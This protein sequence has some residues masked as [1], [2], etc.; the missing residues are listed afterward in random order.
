MRKLV[1]TAA[2]VSITALQAQA[3][4]PV[5][6]AAEVQ[7]AYKRVKEN[8]LKAVEKMPDE[9]FH[10]KPHD[11]VRTYA[12]VVNHISEAQQATCSAVLG[13][14]AGKVPPET[15]SK[16]D[17]MKGL[18]DSFKVCDDAYASVTDANLAQQIKTARGSRSR[19]GA[20]WG[21]VSHDNEQ[22]AILS[23]YLRDKNILPPTSE[24]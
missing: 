17:I 12:R 10:F 18:Q 15:A 2:V 13:V 9:S 7:A 1:L 24:K 3:P 19:I 23:D 4:A 6:P 22:Y 14:E 5:G 21:N 8:V 20:L 11:D 16:A